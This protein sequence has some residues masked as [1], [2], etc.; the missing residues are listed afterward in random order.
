M[1]S[2]RASSRCDPCA[3]SSP[4]P[5]ARGSSRPCR[6]SS[7]TAAPTS[8]RRRSTRRSAP[9]AGSSCGSSSTSPRIRR[10]STTSS[11]RWRR[12]SGWNGGS[13][14]RASASGWGSSS[15]A[16]TTACS[17]CSGARAAASSRRR[18]SRSSRTIPTSSHRRHGVRAPLRG[19]PRRAGPEGRGRRRR[20]SSSSAGGWTSLVLARY[21]QILSAGFLDAIGVPVINI[22]HSFL[23]AFVGADPY[24]RAYERGVKIIGATAHYVTEELDAGPDHRPGRRSG[25]RIATTSPTSRRSGATSSGSC[26][27]AP[28]AGTW[29]TASSS[30]G[31]GPTCSSSSREA[32]LAPQEGELVGQRVAVELVARR[33]PAELLRLPRG[34]EDRADGGRADGDVVLPALHEQV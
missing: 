18:S 19:R 3:R 30:T 29:T 17:S 27:P 24:R 10:S 20:C 14:A 12:R 22:H 26:W 5:T 7:T 4:A 31:L 2:T 32:E 34:G 8:W 15:R 16:T 23:P 6:R 1:P 21:M 33:V 13:P 28:S 9:A 11:A 25:V